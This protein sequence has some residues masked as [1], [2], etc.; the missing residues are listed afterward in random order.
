MAN[1]QH[2]FFPL[3]IAYYYIVF[4]HILSIY[5]MVHVLHNLILF[6]QI[7]RLNL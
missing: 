7:L 6:S 5:I 1:N 2:W 3:L 4:I